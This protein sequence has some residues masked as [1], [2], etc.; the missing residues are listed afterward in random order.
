LQNDLNETITITSFQINGIEQIPQIP[1]IE[2]NDHGLIYLLNEKNISKNH[3]LIGFI[4]FDVLLLLSVIIVFI[5]KRKS[6]FSSRERGEVIVDATHDNHLLDLEQSKYK[7][8]SNNS[9]EGSSLTMNSYNVHNIHQVIVPPGK[10][11]VIIGTTTTNPITKKQ[12][13]PTVVCIRGHTEGDRMLHVGDQIL[14]IDDIDVSSFMPNDVATI[15]IEKQG[16]TRRIT[17]ARGCSYAQ[18]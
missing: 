17:L 15:M 6:L 8:T 14:M 13:P 10:L 11:N 2:K 9:I 4:V 5:I 18:F 1:S 3:F 7:I 12:S 16:F